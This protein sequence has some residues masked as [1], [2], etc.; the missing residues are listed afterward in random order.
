MRKRVQRLAAV[1]VLVFSQITA[2][3]TLAPLTAFA[4]G[5]TFD[6]VSRG[7]AGDM[8]NDT[9]GAG[10]VPQGI[11]SDGRYVLFSSYAT[12]VV[13][14][15]TNGH[16]DLFRRDRSTGTI[17]LVSVTSAGVQG[18]GDVLRGDGAISGDGR[19]VVF[20]T[21]ATNFAT[22]DF[23]NGLDIFLKDMQT[24]ALTRVCSSPY[25]GTDCTE[26]SISRDGRYIV[27]SVANIFGGVAQIF[28]YDRTTGQSQMV[29]Q[30]TQGQPANQSGTGWARLS[31]DGRYAVFDSGATNLVAGDTNGKL[32]ILRK[33]M[34]SGDLLR[35]TPSA[36]QTNADSEWPTV[37]DDGRYVVFAS[38]ASNLA[39]ND[40]NHNWDLFVEDTQLNTMELVGNALTGSTIG[41]I[42]GDGSQVIFETMLRLTASDTDSQQDVYSWDL[43]THTNSRLTEHPD[44]SALGVYGAGAGNSSIDGRYTPIF[45]NNMID[46]GDTTPVIEVY[47]YDRGP[48][49]VTAPNVVGTPD[50][51]AQNGWYDG[52]VTIT[53]AASDPEPSSGAPT[54]PPPTLA[55]QEGTHTYTSQPS[56]DPAGNCATGTLS[57]S[58][59]KTDP[60]I[61]YQLSR[62]PNGAGWHDGDVVVT[63]SCTDALSGVASCTA[64]ITVGEGASQTITGTAV[65]LA[66]RSKSVQ[67]ALNVDKTAPTISYSLS[68][69]ANGAGWHRADTIVTFTCDDALSGV[70]SCSGPQTVGEGANQTVTGSAVDVAGNTATVQVTLNVDKT[71][72]SIGYSLS[73]ASPVS[74]SGWYKDDV[75]IAFQCSDG[76][77]GLLSCSQPTT[78]GEGASQGITGIAED[79]AG[80]SNTVTATDINIDKTAPVVASQSFSTN[81]KSTSQSSDVL[82]VQVSDNLSGVNRVEYYDP[83]LGS[84]QPM[85]LSGPTATALVNT[86]FMVYPAGTYTF[87]V[88][89]WDRADNQSAPTSINLYVYNPSGGHV[90]GVGTVQAGGVTSDPGDTLPAVPGN[91]VKASFGF[92]VKYPNALAT[93][94]AGTSTFSYGQACNS[95]HNNCFTMATD[96]FAWL[97]VPPSN[98]RAS[99]QGLASLALNGQDRGA[100]YPVRVSVEDNGDLAD[101]YLLQIYAA[102]ADPETATPLYQAS[103]DLAGGSILVHP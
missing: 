76:L 69:A 81:P 41:T 21:F 40:T 1:A 27:Y 39:P 100:G 2:G 43:A 64:P 102:G 35:I 16:N 80:N 11:S 91:N 14:N 18:N 17:Q 95:P 54:T 86:S 96:S 67:V 12:N 6:W 98:D 49:D 31:A 87:M 78:L 83:A 101:H 93:A 50:R 55:E 51:G 38:V 7:Y 99:F 53:W 15:D 36:T 88:R 30:N 29:T 90:T 66:G 92:N 25:S 103:G 37:S 22:Q 47:M 28:R 26:D 84:W 46:P 61:S 4:A 58:I 13:Q 45:T 32:D 24:G 97:I 62:A 48:S 10:A 33:D 20:A 42:V 72:P 63:F 9:N 5:G 56:C 34:V 89:A 52:N 8:L 44:G 75:T 59:D 74:A 65:D 3:L 73:S 82:T 60:T 57:L 23:N 94:P 70:A 77:S 19:Y 68:Q 85:L 71:L 79:I